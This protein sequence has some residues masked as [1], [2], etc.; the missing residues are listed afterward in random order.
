MEEKQVNDVNNKPQFAIFDWIVSLPVIRI[1]KPLYEWKKAFWIYCFLGLLS[2]IANYVFTIVFTESLGLYG[3]VAN[4]LA[5]LLSTLI[6][7]VLFRYLYFDRT[8]NSFINELVKFASARI[9]TLGVE[10]LTVLVFVDILGIDIK[11]VKAVL[12]PVTAILNYFISKIFVFKNKE[13]KTA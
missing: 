3:T 13:E 12:I 2:T 8:N 7:F 9:F 5:W 1:V 11:I 6:S 10:T 4:V